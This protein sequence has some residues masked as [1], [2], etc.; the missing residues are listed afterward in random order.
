MNKLVDGLYPPLQLCFQQQV[1]ADFNR[2][3][4]SRS[5]PSNGSMGVS[6]ACSTSTSQLSQSFEND[7]VEWNSEN[8]RPPSTTSI[9]CS[10]CT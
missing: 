3:A 7:L 4:S 10:V 2:A 9:A 8:R 6:P 1:T 5:T